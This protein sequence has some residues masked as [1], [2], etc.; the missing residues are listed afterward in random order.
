M[1]N[2]SVLIL[3]KN[4]ALHIKRCLE[5][6]APLEPRQI[7]VVDCFS[8][9]GSD[10]T[11]AEMGATVVYHEWLGNQAAQFQ[12]ALDNLQIESSWI[13]RLDA[14]EYLTDELIEEIKDKLS[15]IEDDV[16]GVVLKRRHIVGWLN[17]S[18][19][20]RGMYPT[21]IL[22][23][24]RKGYGRSDM[25]IMDEHIVVE[26][27]VVEFDYDF[28]DHSLITF[29]EWREKHRTY[30]K[31]EAQSYLLGEHS[32]GEKAAK[33]DA[34]YKLPRYF[35]TLLYFCVRYFLKGGFLDGRAGWRWHFWQGLWYRWIVDRE[36]GRM[37]R[38]G[39][40]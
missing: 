29:D 9:D 25:K 27:K 31:R 40:F 6:L 23:L 3:Q 36:I 37:K 30:A 39:G 15:R 28:V 22:R 14:D 17:N 19:V 18:W 10:K 8:T 24:F 7:F 20:K 4:E 26:R 35:R 21:K 32:T 5:K 33:K 38:G 34:Y 2:I 16:G 12:W 11:V 1:T 13:L